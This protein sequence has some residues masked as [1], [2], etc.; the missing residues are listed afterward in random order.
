MSA[1]LPRGRS[2]GVSPHVPREEAVLHLRACTTILGPRRLEAVPRVRA[3]WDREAAD[4][5]LAQTESLA[6]QEPPRVL[7]LVTAKDPT[8]R[9][10]R[11]SGAEDILLLFISL[12]GVHNLLG[13]W[14]ETPFFLY[15]P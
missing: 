8:P 13:C 2:P 3:Q 14:D 6:D 11:R 9:R 1:G 7:V 5:V 12:L 4:L 15:L 10:P